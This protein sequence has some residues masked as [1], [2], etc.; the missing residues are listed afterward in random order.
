MRRSRAL[1]R[2]GTGLGTGE[3]RRCSTPSP[4]SRM[5]ARR[6]PP[7][8][9]SLRAA[10]ALGRWSSEGR[11]LNPSRS[12]GLDRT[13]KSAALT[14]PAYCVPS[15]TS[16]SAR[17]RRLGRRRMSSGI[18][19]SLPPASTHRTGTASGM[20]AASSRWRA[21]AHR[22]RRRR[23]SGA[24]RRSGMSGKA[25]EVP[26]RDR[27]QVVVTPALG[28]LH[29]VPRDRLC[30]MRAL[31]DPIVQRPRDPARGP[32]DLEADTMLHRRHGRPS[33]PAARTR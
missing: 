17:S 25:F 33:K 18:V 16:A 3:P 15:P 20:V 26:A 6:P 19:S 13:W 7:P 1:H 27:L 28:P 12:R 31:G 23:A 21:L 29:R 2:A 30:G 9:N 22:R 24:P 14:G 5:V 11:A 8:W 4:G 32:L 10:W